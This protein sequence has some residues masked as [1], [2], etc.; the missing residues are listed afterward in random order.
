MLLSTYG[1]EVVRRKYD[2]IATDMAYENH[3]SWQLGPVSYVADWFVL[4]LP[5][6]AALRER[7]RFV[8]DGLKL[9]S[10][11][12]AASSEGSVVRILSAPCGAGRDLA[13]FGAELSTENPDLFNRLDVHALDLDPTNEALPLLSQRTAD[14]GLDVTVYQQDLLR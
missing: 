12:I 10:T 8:A 2:A 3:R 1:R 9:A 11:E 4:G 14:A 13:T 5:T 6:H 7:L